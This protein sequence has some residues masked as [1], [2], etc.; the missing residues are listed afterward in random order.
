MCFCVCVCVVGVL[1][2]ME[3]VIAPAVKS[4]MSKLISAADQGKLCR[5][6]PFSPFLLSPPS[7]SLSLS[8]SLTLLS[9]SLPSPLSPPPSLC[10]KSPS[11]F[12]FTG[13][14]FAFIASSELF[15]TIIATTFYP[16]VFP[17]LLNHHLR[18]GAVYFIMA[19]LCI[20]PF[21]LLL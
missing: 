12:S 16:N 4:F 21:L 3:A 2:G 15:V 18:P 6:S 1:L 13:A 7:L 20:A 17:V 19:A 5:G 14:M 11:N 8:I 9:F 10:H